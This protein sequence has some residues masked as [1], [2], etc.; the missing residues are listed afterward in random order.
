MNKTLLVVLAFLGVF[1]CG[2]TVGGVVTFRF[3]RQAVQKKAA[4]HIGL[5]QW[6]KMGEQLELTAEQR[7]KIRPLVVR[8]AQD[9]Q[10]A[11]K[12]AQ[13]FNDRLVE[14]LEAFF[15]P[16]QREKFQELRKRQR[17][18]DRLWQ[19][20]V[21]EQ[22]QRRADMAPLGFGVEAGSPP[23]PPGAPPPPKR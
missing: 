16:E 23:V 11:L 12:Q 17:D 22:R 5:Q 21:R 18:T 6:R 3:G 10:A 15:M 9:R 7:E 2:A 14:D 4:E 13:V 1:V 8:A 20:W 19:R